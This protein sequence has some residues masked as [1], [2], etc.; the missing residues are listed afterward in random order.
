MSS[1]PALPDRVSRAL[2]ERCRR[3]SVSTPVPEAEYVSVTDEGK[4]VQ[5]GLTDGAYLSDKRETGNLAPILQWGKPLRRSERRTGNSGPRWGHRKTSLAPQ[6]IAL[7]VFLL[8]MAPLA[9]LGIG[10]A[11]AASGPSSNLTPAT[12][13][14]PV[15]FGGF[16][17]N[18]RHY[19]IFA[20]VTTWGG[21]FES[22]TNNT[23]V[24]ASSIE[25]VIYSLLPTPS[26]LLIV[27]TENGVSTSQ[28][29][30]VTD[31]SSPTVVSVNLLPIH[32][33]TSVT[34]SVDETPQSYSVSVPISFL[35]SNIANVGGLDLIALAIISECLVALALAVSLA[36]GTM[37]KALWA[38]HFSLLVWGHVIL[39]SIAASVI[40]DFQQV[41]ELFAGWSPL[42]YAVFLFPIFFIFSLSFFNKARKVEML[43]AR[44]PLSGRLSFHRWEFYLGRDQK[45]RWVVIGPRWGDWLAR[46]FGHHVPITTTETSVDTPE[47]FM[48][49]IVNH[50]LLS[51]EQ[52]ERRVR[53]PSPAKSSAFE[54]FDIIPVTLEG[55]A[56]SGSGRSEPPSLLLF[57]PVGRP[58]NVTFPHL[59]VHKDKL[60]PARLDRKSGE[61]IIP[62]HHANRLCLPYYTEGK[63][64]ITL[65]LI[66][67]RSS[68]SV[69]NG[70]R[71]A[72]SLALL[73]ADTQLDL[74]SLK[75][76]I[77]ETVTRL[78]KEQTLARE[79]LLHRGE[80]DLPAEEAV[81][82]AE[83]DKTSSIPTLEELFGRG[84]VLP[85][86]LTPKEPEEKKKPK[87][88]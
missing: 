42:F 46:A 71:N 47:P 36:Y 43:Q 83:R 65:H 59:S 8:V 79:S 13:G 34:M 10:S 77:T 58:V 70:W 80:T 72:D 1:L 45:G 68:I 52:I 78:V 24:Y 3:G 61:V 5:D 12:S 23:Q 20:G 57:T 67:F 32:S 64:D 2:P 56:A 28:S 50:R 22:I 7:L 44:A 51:R 82:E 11:R 84:T 25:L 35:P 14:L 21:G 76:H 81:L 31:V 88:A 9:S 66:H 48:A 53:N 39:I 6:G 19:L 54:D 55:R 87:G 33:W 26:T 86:G 63:A 75:S 37:R 18:D 40:L 41:D 30:A 60:I 69:T 85:R 17:T 49:D 62:E 16:L 74:E 38:P 27:S 73:L 29:V 4:K 15:Q